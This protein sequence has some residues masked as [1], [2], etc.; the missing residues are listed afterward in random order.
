MPNSFYVNCLIRPTS[1]EDNTEIVVEKTSE[2]K[3][4]DEFV[5][6][7]PEAEARYAIYGPFPPFFYSSMLARRW[8]FARL[9]PDMPCSPTHTSDRLRI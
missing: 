7:L 4:Y 1:S 2:S 5:E 8:G 6:Q 9:C 3:D